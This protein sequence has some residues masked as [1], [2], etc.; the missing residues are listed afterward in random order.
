MNVKEDDEENMNDKTNDNT[1]IMTDNNTINKIAKRHLAIQFEKNLENPQK[2]RN[3]DE[4]KEN[5]LS[6]G[7]PMAGNNFTFEDRKD[8]VPSP[9]RE[10]FIQETQPLCPSENVT[11]EEADK[12]NINDA[13]V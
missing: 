4:K 6:F 7:D 2:E 13:D 8:V 10:V 1:P 9:K 12:E 3:K 11:N 5:Q